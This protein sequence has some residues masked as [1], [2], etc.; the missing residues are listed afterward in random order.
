MLLGASPELE[1]LLIRHLHSRIQDSLIVDGQMETGFTLP[2]ILERIL[3]GERESRKVRESVLIYR[4]LDAVRSEGMGVVGLPPTLNALHEGRVRMLLVR[5]GLAK[6]GRSCPH[7]GAL[8]VTGKKCAYCWRDTVPTMNLVADLTAKALEQGCEVV[9]ILNDIRLDTFGGVGAE[10]N[11]APARPASR[12]RAGPAEEAPVAIPA[13]SS[14]GGPP[15]AEK[16]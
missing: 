4:L 2:E 5:Q 16:A 14:V 9:Q 12:P 11:S 10:L 3:T 1:P 8:S 13:A 6:I 15:P 7:C